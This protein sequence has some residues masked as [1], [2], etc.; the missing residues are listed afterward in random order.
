MALAWGVA[1]PMPTCCP[2]PVERLMHANKKRMDFF[3]INVFKMLRER[4]VV[5][6]KIAFYGPMVTGYIE[7]SSFWLQ[8]NYNSNIKVAAKKW[9]ETRL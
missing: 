1:V 9:W 7:L 8:V 4:V 6:K 3:I 2:K 5:Y